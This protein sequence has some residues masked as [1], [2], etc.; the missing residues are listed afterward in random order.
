MLRV[1]FFAIWS[2]AFVLFLLSNGALA[3]VD[4]PAKTAQDTSKEASAPPTRIAMP[5]ITVTATRYEEAITNVP[6]NLSSLSNQQMRDKNVTRITEALKDTVGIGIPESGNVSNISIL[7]VRGVNVPGGPLL[8]DTVGSLL[9]GLSISKPIPGFS[10]SFEPGKYPMFNVERIEVLKGPASVLYGKDAFAGVINLISKKPK[11]GPVASEMTFFANQ[12]PS[13]G[14][15]VDV[16]SGDELLK[17][18]AMFNVGFGRH[19]L[20]TFRDHSQGINEQMYGN[21]SFELTKKTHLRVGG[22]YSHYFQERPS[23][24]TQQQLD[25]DRDQAGTSD[26]G[27]LE[28][29]LTLIP[30]NLEHQFS[31]DVTLTNSFLYNNSNDTLNLNDLIVQIGR[32]RLGDDPSKRIIN[33]T[34][35]TWSSLLFGHANELQAGLWIDHFSANF[36]FKIRDLTTNA[37]TMR[38]FGNG[39]QTIFSPYFLNRFNLTDKAI[40]WTG[41]RWD[42]INMNRVQDVNFGDPGYSL[43]TSFDAYSP[44][45]GLVYHFTEESSAYFNWSRSFRPISLRAITPTEVG[46]GAVQENLTNYEVG[47]RYAT[48]DNRLRV[49]GA[50]FWMTYDDQVNSQFRGFDPSALN[51]DGQSTHRGLEFE[52]FYELVPRLNAGFSIAYL[53]AFINKLRTTRSNTLI[54]LDGARI[55]NVP[56]WSLY[57]S[58]S[59]RTEMG[60]IGTVNGRYI[61]DRFGDQWNT[62]KLPSFFLLD[63]SLGYQPEGKPYGITASLL[64]IADEKYNTIAVRFDPFITPTFDPGS[65]RTFAVSVWARF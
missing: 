3:Q 27:F 10:T 15:S 37:E 7:H 20:N 54:V 53:D 47:A 2:I 59:Y 19:D 6:Y 31:K 5:E 4:A 8:N 11:G 24:L 40:L 35:V 34:R 41:L 45:V 44:H 65:P 64:N 30:V 62:V 57:P 50:A 17:K 39:R 26:P 12:W 49:R 61:G 48:A 29:Y 33:D 14:G 51:R 43:T 13:Y 9:D 58:L 25:Q 42:R 56:R 38:E 55:H 18:P 22:S 46:I 23:T 63:L 36:L 52:G 32:R 1:Q 16:N 28:T 21:L 60:L